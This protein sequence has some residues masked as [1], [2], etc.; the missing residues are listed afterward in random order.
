MASSYLPYVNSATVL[1]KFILDNPGSP[2]HHRRQIRTWLT[3]HDAKTFVYDIMQRPPELMALKR[4][5]DYAKLWLH[6]NKTPA[7]AFFL[8]YLQKGKNAFR[9]RERPDDAEF[10]AVRK[11][12]FVCE[13][14]NN[15]PQTRDWLVHV[16]RDNNLRPGHLKS[17]EYHHHARIIWATLVET[18]PLGELVAN[19]DVL[20]HHR[21]LHGTSATAVYISNRLYIA[22]VQGDTQ[23]GAQVISAAIEHYDKLR[24]D[25]L[26]E[27]FARC[28]LLPAEFPI[29]V[30]IDA[31][32]H[33]QH[34]ILS[35][36]VSEL[37]RRA[38]ETTLITAVNKAFPHQHPEALGIVLHHTRTYRQFVGRR[39]H[40]ELPIVIATQNQTP[41]RAF[42]VFTND[43]PISGNL[44]CAKALQ[45]YNTVM[46]YSGKQ[47]AKLV[48]VGLSGC[49][50]LIAEKGNPNM[51]DVV[52]VD[53]RTPRVIDAFLRK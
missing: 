13:N 24:V 19:L 2:Y 51:L 31:S 17:I 7:F 36:M 15:R 8:R 35:A 53:E 44:L 32:A 25:N 4:V 43:Y 5:C 22:S 3:K 27:S 49:E 14:W 29:A 39:L 48:V 9:Y 45:M 50:F 16:I 11:L 34:G 18:L 26:L 42:F 47:E 33:K 10:T 21:L 46:G 37:S 52:G 12:L 1:E 40:C 41:V 23:L 28:P 6:P 30:G 38:S 20:N